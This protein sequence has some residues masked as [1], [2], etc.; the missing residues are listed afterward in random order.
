MKNAVVIL[1]ILIAAGV[2]Y[3]AYSK[4]QEREMAVRLTEAIADPGAYVVKTWS[5]RAKLECDYGVSDVVTRQAP[6]GTIPVS[7][8]CKATTGTWK[9]AER[10]CT[11]AENA[12]SSGSDVLAHGSPQNVGDVYRPLYSLCW[13]VVEK[14]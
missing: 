5:K 2:A 8:A 1:L 4:Y 6:G 13:E 3:L 10:R 7:F 14:Q 12:P 11:E 9:L